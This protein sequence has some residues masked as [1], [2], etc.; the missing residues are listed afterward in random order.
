[1]RIN[2]EKKIDKAGR[3]HSKRSTA[4]GGMFK[5]SSHQPSAQIIGTPAAQ[6]VNGIGVLLAAQEEDGIAK[7]KRAAV[8]RGTNML[9]MLDRLK[10][11]YLNGYVAPNT[12]AELAKLSRQ[13]SN[14]LE[15]QP[16]QR[17][18]KSIELRAEVEL[19]KIKQQKITN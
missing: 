14:Q 19:A 2:G 3:G 16:L 12:L 7:Q 11:S 4:P 8:R 18:I 6:S 1:M 15:D 17:V 13:T 5:V 9:D 10:L